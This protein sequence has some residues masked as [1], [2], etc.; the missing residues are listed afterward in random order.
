V[1]VGKGGGE[2]RKGKVMPLGLSVYKIASVSPDTL[3]WSVTY[4]LSM[5]CISFDACFVWGSRRP[6]R[7]VNYCCGVSPADRLYI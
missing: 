2:Q 5:S 3:I 6:G 7:L 1:R 4:M